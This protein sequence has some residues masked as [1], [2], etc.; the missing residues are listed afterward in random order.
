MNPLTEIQFRVPFDKIEAAQVEPA[1]D[2]LL[3]DAAQSVDRAIASA[4]VLHAID[5]MTERLDYALNVVRHLET[6]ATIGRRARKLRDLNPTQVE[7]IVLEELSI[8]AN[9]KYYLAESNR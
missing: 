5:T 4:D 3:A 7:E 6:V 9:L 2:E 1:V 8:D